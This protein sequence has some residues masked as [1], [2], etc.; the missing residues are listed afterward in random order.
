M[1][2]KPKY[3]KDLVFNEMPHFPSIKSRSAVTHLWTYCCSKSECGN[4]MIS[5]PWERISHKHFRRTKEQQ[6]TDI[7]LDQIV[8]ETLVDGVAWRATND[9][10]SGFTRWGASSF[11]A[12]NKLLKSKVNIIKHIKV[13]RILL[14]SA[15]R[16][17]VKEH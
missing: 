17:M 2:S 15:L 16:A 10:T 7:P 11:I 6:Q 12:I 8:V 4:L 5:M 9:L 13:W 1:W 3:C 14:T